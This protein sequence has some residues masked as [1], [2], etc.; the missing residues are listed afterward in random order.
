MKKSATKEI[1]EAINENSIRINGLEHKLDGLDQSIATIN[2][3]LIEHDKRFEILEERTAL[4]PKLYDNTDKLVK[5]ILENRQ[6]RTFIN[7][8]LTNHEGRITKLENK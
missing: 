1:L 3:K 5:E 8:K 7:Q 6:E 4:I 2:V